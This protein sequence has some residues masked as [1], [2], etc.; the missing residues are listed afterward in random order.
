MFI[1]KESTKDHSTIRT[2]MFNKPGDDTIYS[3]TVYSSKSKAKLNNADDCQKFTVAD[4]TL[5]ILRDSKHNNEQKLEAINNLLS[6]IGY[7]E[8]T[9]EEVFSK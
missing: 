2:A 9:Y 8:K 5:K 7:P 1:Y 3:Y 6:I 4:K